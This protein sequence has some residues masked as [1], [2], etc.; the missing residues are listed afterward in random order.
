MASNEELALQVQQ[1]DSAA[2]EALWEAVKKL[3]YK[4]PIFL[5][6]TQR[7]APLLALHWTTCNRKVSLLC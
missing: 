6:I 3:C 4:K 7:P 2:T 1:G 5:I